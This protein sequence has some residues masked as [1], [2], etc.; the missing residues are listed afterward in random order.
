MVTAPVNEIGYANAASANW[1][2]YDVSETTPE[3]QW[4]RSVYVYDQMRRQDAQVASVLRAVSLP[5][6]RT[7]W[8]VDPAGAKARV[9]QFIADELGLPVVGKDPKPAPRSRD[10]FS[11]SEHLAQALLMLPFGHMYFEQ[12]YRIDAGGG[13]A[14]LRKLGPRMPRTIDRIDVAPDGGLV[15]ITQCAPV[16]GRTPQP[17]P[18]SR[19]VA[20]V[21]D[22]E[23]GNWLGMSLLRP[24]YKHWLIKDRLLRVQAQ[25]VERNG[26][27]VPLYEA[28]ENETDL[29][30]GL[31]MSKAWRAGESSGSAIP[32]GAKMRLLGVEGTLPDADKPI[33]YHD[34]QI[35]RAVLAHFLNLGTQTGSWALGTTFADFFTLSLQTLAQQIADVATQHIVEDLVDINFGPSEPAPR[36][37]FDEI[38]SRQAAT[39]AALKSLSDA[40]LIE[41]DDVL[42]QSIRQQYGMP[43]PDPATAPPPPAPAPVAP[44]AQPTLPGMDAPVQ[45]A[46]GVDT[47]PGGE[48]LKKYWLHGEGA[49][50]WATWTEL[51][52]HLV[53]YLTPEMAKRTAAEWFHER[54]GYWPGDQ[55]N[56]QGK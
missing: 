36:V 40:G 35:A 10:K 18:V 37:V 53:K 44:P 42:K 32:F 30:A 13:R 55:R 24:A 50:K 16:G 43:A 28:A 3:L 46:A 14:H 29:S 23:G 19:L 15:S 1:W 38:G 31:A 9:T 45:A 52:Q 22:K 34:E 8:R 54:Y 5:V 20:Y 12:V 4:P 2:V 26:M 17:I 47:H 33:R 7:P 25:T 21:L 39:A 49:A 56:Q 51:Y 6:R 41:P 48:Q 27:G 11:W